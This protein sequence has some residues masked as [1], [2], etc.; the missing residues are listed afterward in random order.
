MKKYRQILVLSHYVQSLSI[1]SKNP[2]VILYRKII[3]FLT[4]IYGLDGLWIHQ[5]SSADVEPELIYQSQFDLAKTADPGEIKS[6]NSL[7]NSPRFGQLNKSEILNEN[8][9][10]QL[11][12]YVLNGPKGLEIIGTNKL[13]SEIE[14]CKKIKGNP[15]FFKNHYFTEKNEGEPE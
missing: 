3:G 8:S 2:P 10:E 9:P 4:K 5:K 1:I 13:E 15:V 7:E 14:S 11:Q 12:E 6:I